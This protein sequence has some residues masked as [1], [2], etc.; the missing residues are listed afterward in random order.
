LTPVSLSI[1]L[2][3]S[4]VLTLLLVLGHLLA[5]ISAFVSLDGVALVLVCTGIAVSLV[6]SVSG[7]L[8][9]TADAPVELQLKADGQ[10]SWRDRRGTW[11]E[12]NIAKGGYVSP[13][14]VLIPL[15]GTGRRRKWIVIPADAA[16]AEDHRQLRIW[17]RWQHGDVPPAAK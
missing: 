9:R 17:L 6:A 1:C 10:A 16:S 13:W 12:T 4:P 2:R 15:D 8:G 14:L 11:H 7:L 5:L 3:P